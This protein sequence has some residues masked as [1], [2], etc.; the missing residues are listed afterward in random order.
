MAGTTVPTPLYPL[1][2]QEFGFSSLTVTVVFAVYA[3]GVVVALI[4]LGRVSDQIGRRPVILAALFLAV[5]ANTVFLAAEDLAMI[6]VARVLAGF[7]TALVTGAA[8]A[9]LA[10][11]IKSPQHPRRAATMAIFANMGGLATGTLL[12]G[13][14]SDVAPDPLRLPWAIVLFLV[15]IAIIAIIGLPE[16]V[17]QRSALRLRLERLRIPP[18]IRADFVRAAMTAG[19]G[20][21]ALGVITAVS[22]L[23]LGTILHET[24]HTLAGLVVFLA[25]LGAAFGQLLIRVLP[26]RNALTYAC[27]G[28]IVAA[29]LLA[30]TMWVAALAPLLIGA[31]LNGVAAGVAIG[32]GLATITTRAAPEHRG[33]AVSTF[34]AILYGMLGV[35]VVGVG[36]LIQVVGLRTAGEIFSAV[37]ALLALAVLLSLTR[38]RRQQAEA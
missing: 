30:L 17:A 13:I 35:P 21:A 3:L 15:V 12:A 31:A 38:G 24:S 33:E 25:F 34:F 4:T 18:E 27:M 9:A 16:S 20:F 14:V 10:E 36:L 23:F 19:A 1:Y 11:L 32:H 22:G 7:A 5:A 37:V 6:I 8:T 2:E 26:P 29:G 28:I